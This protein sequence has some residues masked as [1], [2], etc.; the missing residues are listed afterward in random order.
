MFNL[1]KVIFCFVICLDKNIRQ[2]SGDCGILREGK[3]QAVN[4]ESKRYFFAK[5]MVNE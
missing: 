2:N 3:I 4:C 1:Y 5:V